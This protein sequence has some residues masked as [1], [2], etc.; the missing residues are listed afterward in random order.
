MKSKPAIAGVVAALLLLAVFAVY[1][2]ANAPAKG[3]MGAWGYVASNRDASLAVSERQSGIATLTV[4]HVCVPEPAWIVVT[5]GDAMSGKPLS[6]KHIDKGTST[7]VTLRLQGV[8]SKGVLVGVYADRGVPGRFDFDPNAKTTSPDKPFF[9][10]GK[11]L[12]Q[13][14]VLR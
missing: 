12:I 1:A 10:S 9:V 2:F 7:D 3:S 11:E 13:T 8:E 14:V 6:L 5:G 4:A